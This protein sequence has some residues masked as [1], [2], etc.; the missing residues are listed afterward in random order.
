LFY[1]GVRLALQGLELWLNY[2]TWISQ[3]LAQI[4]IKFGIRSIP[5]TN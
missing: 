5:K 3:S 4:S 2:A 1:S